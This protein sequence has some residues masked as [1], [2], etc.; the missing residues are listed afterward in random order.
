MLSIGQLYGGKICAALDRQHPRDLFDIKYLFDNEGFSKDV[1][2]GFLLAL[3]GSDRPMHE[4]LNQNLL[5][6]RPAMSNQFSGMSYESFT[7]NDFEQTRKKLISV[8]NNELSSED[9]KFLLSIKNLSPDWDIYDFQKFP[10]IQWKIQ[11]IEKLKLKNPDK[12]RE[13][14]DLLKR[15]L[16]IT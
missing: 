13:Q 14:L 9:K 4:F 7:Y 3:A 6:Q 15:Q 8:V 16:E 10:S 11:N 2:T 1:K 12:Y 5:D